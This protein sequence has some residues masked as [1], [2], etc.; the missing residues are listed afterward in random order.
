M[1]DVRQQ[2]QKL[3]SIK[4]AIIKNVTE[5]ELIIH[6]DAK[7]THSKLIQIDDIIKILNKHL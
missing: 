4:S 5:C 1:E 2:K 6:S 3:Y 7:K